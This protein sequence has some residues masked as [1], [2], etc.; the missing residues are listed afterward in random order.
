MGMADR[1]VV[2]HEGVV[3]EI[4]EREDFKEE[5]IMRAAMG[6]AGNAGGAA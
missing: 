2:M 3:S 5:R 1:V 4:I 6:L